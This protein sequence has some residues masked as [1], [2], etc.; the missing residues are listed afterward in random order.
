MA[1]APSR[2]K[3]HLKVEKGELNLTSM[4][5]AMTIIL[6]FLLKTYSTHGQIVSPSKDLVLPYSLSKEPPKKELTVSVTRENVSVSDKV[7]MPVNSIRPNDVMIAP[8]YQELKKRAEEAKQN[9][10]LYAIPFDHE[11]LIQGD[12]EIPFQLLFK[13]LYTCGQSEYNKLRLLT[14]REK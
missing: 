9:E 12:Q 8:L 1:F 4:M 13:V 11:I 2:S 14:I 3:K 7:V 5:D 6:L 10:I